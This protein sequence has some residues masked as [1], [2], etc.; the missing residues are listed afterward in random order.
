MRDIS[1]TLA[2][3]EGT[4]WEVR[5]NGGVNLQNKTASYFIRKRSV[6]LRIAEYCTSSQAS[7]SQVRDKS[8]CNREQLLSYPG[9]QEVER[10][11]RNKK[12]T[13]VSWNVK[14]SDFS[15]AE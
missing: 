5:T 6:H 13:G 15:L 14:H 8:I 2:A 12:F 4:N 3:K 1:K 11:V 9:K 7:Y 10:A